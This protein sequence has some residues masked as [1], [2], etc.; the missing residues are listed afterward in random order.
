MPRLDGLDVETHTIAGNFSFTGAR[1]AGLGATEYTIVNIAVDTTG[2]LD[3]FQGDLLVMLIASVEACAKSPRSEN[4]LIRVVEFN[5]TFPTGV[6]EIH[7]FLPLREI[8]TSD[9]PLFRPRGGTPL[10]DAC[11]GTVG[12]TSA[13]GQQLYENEMLANGIDF[14]ITDGENTRSVATAAMVRGEL[15]KGVATEI[16]ESHL[17]VIIGMGME[18][19]SKEP[20][21]VQRAAHLSDLLQRFSEEIDPRFEPELPSD[22][23]AERDRK[24]AQRTVRLIPSGDVTKGS[25]AKIAAFVSQSISSQSQSIGTG[26]PSQSIAATV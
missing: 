14:I 6:S 2:S 18:T 12:A 17:L 16:L 4:L 22:G 3:G 20:H 7:G 11:F 1:I 23:Q 8:K 5:S 26:G 10:Y 19:S 9:Y 15:Q 24:A 21:L 25:L 13:Y